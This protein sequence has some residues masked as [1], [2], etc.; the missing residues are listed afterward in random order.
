M[1]VN[2][3]SVQMGVSKMSSSADEGGFSNGGAGFKFNPSILK[4]PKGDD[5]MADAKVFTVL[6]VCIHL[7]PH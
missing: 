2:S 6:K 1:V 4:R 3:D 5:A 7:L